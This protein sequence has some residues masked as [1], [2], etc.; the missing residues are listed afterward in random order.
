MSSLP[1]P[2][3]LAAGRSESASLAVLHDG[4]ADP[5]DARI[6]ADSHV[7]RIDENNLIVLVGGILVDPVRV[8]HSQVGSDSAS[9][10][11]GNTSQV[12]LELELVN[13]LVLGFTMHNA[14][15]DGALS[16]TSTDSNAV[17]NISLLGLVSQLVGL[18]GSG[19]LVNSDNLLG[20]SVFP[21]S[22]Q[23]KLSLKH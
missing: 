4:L 11:L 8:Q 2:S 17:N 5:V 16:T 7:L 12:S 9:T 19:G 3:A 13:S 18:V 10:F 6:V 23:N 1:E 15:A 20:L 22:V 21:S 14:S